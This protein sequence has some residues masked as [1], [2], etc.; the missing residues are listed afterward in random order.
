MG[1]CLEVDATPKSES[2]VQ[3]QQQPLGV[4]DGQGDLLTFYDVAV[5]L[6]QEEWLLLLP[7]QRDLC[8]EVML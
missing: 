4:R 6:T 1:L 3:R 2:C 7:L 8:R 5:N